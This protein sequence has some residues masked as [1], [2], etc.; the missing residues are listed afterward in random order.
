MND[1]WLKE[2]YEKAL[3]IVSTVVAVGVAAWLI[4]GG[5]KFS[6]LFD[7]TSVRPSDEMPETGIDQLQQAS[8]AFEESVTWDGDHLF[9][10]APVLEVDGNLE[11]V[12]E[13]AVH[14]PIEDAWVSQYDLPMTEADLKEQDPDGDNFTNLEEFLGQTDPTDSESHPAFITKLCLSSMVDSDLQLIFRT[15]VDPSTWQID[16]VS[17]GGKYQGRNLL[18]GKTNRFGPN[19]MFRLDG[20]EEKRGV[21]A[22]GVPVDESVV[23][24]SYVEAGGNVR[25]NQELKRE[26]AW[27]LPT[28]EGNFTDQFDGSEFSAKR[29]SSFKLSND[30]DTLF[31]VVEVTAQ[32]AILKDQNGNSYEISPCE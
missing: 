19:N 24:I 27:T 14:D 23:T 12:G 13:G 3:L 25:V 28:H 8:K 20:F 26:D 9:V 10:S 17:P 32:V 7:Q 30:A 29:G 22:N 6:E 16:L 4:M 2:N 18:V 15:Q 5:L 31:T 1:D 11:P 21:D